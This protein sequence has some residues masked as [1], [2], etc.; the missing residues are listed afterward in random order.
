MTE[1]TGTGGTLT[2]TVS[3]SAASGREVTVGYAR[4]GGTATGGVRGAAGVD[5]TTLPPGT[6]TFPAGTTSRTIAVALAGDTADEPGETVV[7]TLSAPANA[8]VATGTGTGTITDDDAAPVVSIDHPRVAEGAAGTAAAL[9]FTV[10]L[11]AASGRTVTV[12]YADAGTGSATSGTDYAALGAGTLTFA[13]GTT[14]QS[15]DVSVTGDGAHEPDETVAVTLSAPV[16]ATLPAGTET[17][18]GTIADDDARPVLSIDSPRVVEGGA[19]TTALLRF[20]V[21]LSAR[22]GQTVTVAYRDAGTGSATSGTD[23]AA[24]APGTLTFAPGTTTQTIDVS[25]TGDVVDEVDE[26]VVVTLSAPVNAGLGTARGTGTVIDDDGSPALS[27][28]S[29]RVAEGDGAT[30]SLASAQP[31]AV[32]YRDAGTGTATSGTDYTAIPPGTLTFAPGTT[33]QIVEV[34][35]IG[36]TQDEAD[37]TVVVVLHTPVEAVIAVGTGTGTIVDDDAPARRRRCRCRRC[38]STLRAWPRV[39]R[40]RPFPCASRSR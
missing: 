5:Y 33:E 37:E 34:S 36:D 23:Y 1:G 35:V 16:N 17:G 4:T 25:V 14:A 6:L 8:T 3:L 40:A 9:R 24:L 21:T 31:V 29:P 38:P 30:V 11:S 39:G 27:I 32:S 26:T 10:S 12:N 18:T 19:G 2:F 28:D 22:S 15:L 7:V 20:T 13:P